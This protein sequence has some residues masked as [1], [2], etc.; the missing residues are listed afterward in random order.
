MQRTKISYG[1]HEEQNE[2]GEIALSDIK[3]YQKA[4]VIKSVWHWL[5]DKEIS[6]A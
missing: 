3:I 6:E 5:K 1:N 4:L 2:I